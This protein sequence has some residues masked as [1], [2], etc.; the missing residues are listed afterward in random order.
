MVDDDLLEGNLKTEWLA[1]S[2]SSGRIRRRPIQGSLN[3]FLL[4]L[5]HQKKRK[6]SEKAKALDSSQSCAD[7]PAISS[8]H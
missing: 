3:H 5:K 8:T 7:P 6:K 4:T 2:E 1:P